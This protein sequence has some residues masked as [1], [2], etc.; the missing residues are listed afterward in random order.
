MKQKLQIVWNLK[1]SLLSITEYAIMQI[2]NIITHIYKIPVSL[3]SL[4]Q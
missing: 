4:K 3:S 2:I 1:Y